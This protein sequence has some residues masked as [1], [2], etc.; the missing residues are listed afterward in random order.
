[1]YSDWDTIRKKKIGRKSRCTSNI[2]Y[3]MVEKGTKTKTQKTLK[4]NRIKAL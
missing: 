4:Q 2:Y 3:M 1:M